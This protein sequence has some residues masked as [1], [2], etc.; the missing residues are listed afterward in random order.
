MSPY[1]KFLRTKPSKQVYAFANPEN[2][3]P[4]LTSY[5]FSALSGDWNCS[6]EFRNKK[7]LPKA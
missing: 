4:I 5:Y 6:D 3:N 2:D 7:K 1:K